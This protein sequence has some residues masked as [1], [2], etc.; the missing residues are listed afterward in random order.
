MTGAVSYQHA[1]YQGTNQ[2]ENTFGASL[3]ADYALTRSVVIRT[4]FTQTRLQSSVPGS[5][6][7]AN[8]LLLGLRLQQ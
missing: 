6:Y 1:Q 5:D 3:R 4:S 8:T 7:T 2:R